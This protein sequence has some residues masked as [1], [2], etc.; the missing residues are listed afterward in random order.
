MV[1]VKAPELI[2]RLS[3][4]LSNSKLS[5]N[6]DTVYITLKRGLSIFRSSIC[7]FFGVF[8]YPFQ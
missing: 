3:R 6:R 8:R 4:S 1:K 7:E 2:D 5:I